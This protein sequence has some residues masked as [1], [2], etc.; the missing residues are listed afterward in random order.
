MCPSVV[1]QGN[2]T[3]IEPNL[4]SLRNEAQREARSRA[5]QYVVVD[6]PVK[7]ILEYYPELKGLVPAQSQQELPNLLER[8]GA[9]QKLLLN[10]PSIRAD[11]TVVQQ[12][13]DKHGWAV[14]LPAFTGHF[15][16]F[17]H[18]HVTGE[19]IRFSEGRTDEHWQPVEPTVPS[20]YSLIK[21]FA[22]LPMH[23]H[24]HHQEASRFRYLGRHTLNNREYYVVAF[25]Q[26]PEKAELLG[27]VRVNGADITV[28]YQGVAWIDPDNFQI[29]RMRTDL[30]MARPEVG[31]EMTETEFTEVHLPVVS[32]SFWLPSEAAV[33][34]STKNGDLL[35]KHQFSDYKIFVK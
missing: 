31:M 27:S 19:G 17:V 29:A 30:L 33:T 21:G 20:G 18:A 26:Q 22:L 15:N 35:E 14:G 13:A 23:F 12:E 6:I 1:G 8:V 5:P 4:R 7:K 25:A 9:N 24:P 10:L 28:A 2:N 3:E 34:R 16:Y 32:K 11:E